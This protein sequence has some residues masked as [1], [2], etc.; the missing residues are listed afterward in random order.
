[1]ADIDSSPALPAS[2]HPMANPGYGKRLAPDQSP[3]TA[4]DF[5]HLP[6][7]EASVAA[8]IDR[9]PEGSA[10]GHK[11]LAGELEYGQQ[12]CLSAFRNLTDAGHLRHI[13]EHLTLGDSSMRWVTR[14]YWSRTPRDEEWWDEFVRSIHGVDVTV[15]RRAGGLARVCEPERTS[16]PDPEPQPERSDAYNLLAGLGRTEPRMTLSAAECAALEPLAAEWLAR[17]ATPDHL[18]RTL[19]AGLPH[20]LHSPGAIA[21]TRL[22]NKMPP[23][24]T[25]V[26]GRVTRVVMLCSVC[27][28]P[29]TTTQ[30]IRGLC[31]DCR[32][33]MKAD[34]EQVAWLGV[35]AAKALKAREERKTGGPV[36]D[37]FR[38]VPIQDRVD[39]AFRADQAR[40]A[41]GIAPR[42]LA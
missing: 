35:T 42:R 29:E 19:T 36:A 15:H 7:R 27:E 26:R 12:A 40:I 22:E 33:D 31:L 41:A 38:S 20:P 14:T 30:L 28:A 1:M 34:V 25:P 18:T 4:G 6:K 11:V 13:K 2:A 32:E 17:G 5:A 3:P 37:T 24:S 21:R 8:F 10:M 9:L 39:Y 16:V 23:E